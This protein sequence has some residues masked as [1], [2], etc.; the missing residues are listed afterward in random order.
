[1]YDVY[2][3]NLL[4]IY[5]IY[6]WSIMFFPSFRR[7]IVLPLCSSLSKN[8][9]TLPACHA[10]LGGDQAI[11]MVTLYIM[12]IY[13]CLDI[14]AYI[15]VYSCAY[16]YMYVYINVYLYPYVHRN[17][18]SFVVR[19]EPCKRR[20]FRIK[21]RINLFIYISILASLM[22]GFLLQQTPTCYNLTINSCEANWLVSLWL[23]FLGLIIFH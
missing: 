8:Q 18:L 21:T 20:P 16:I 6:F 14:C 5:S 17:S 10:G 15:Y 22:I 13:I 2:C 19:V 12:Y 11:V 9:G 7:P 4:N 23:I 1:M 3:V